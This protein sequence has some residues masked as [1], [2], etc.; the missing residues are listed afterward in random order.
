MFPKNTRLDKHRLIDWLR[1][2]QHD[3]RTK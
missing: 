2:S 3:R 1:C